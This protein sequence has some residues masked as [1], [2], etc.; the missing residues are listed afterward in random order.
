MLTTIRSLLCLLIITGSFTASAEAIDYSL[1]DLEGKTVSLADYKGKW[2]IVN[3]WATWCPPC[4]E[5]IPDMIKFHDEHKDKDAV[6]LGINAED[7]GLEQLVE[8]TDSMFISYPILRSEP[9][10]ESPLGA[11]PGLPTTYIISPEGEAVARQ[12]GPI[13]SEMIE[14]FISKKKTSSSH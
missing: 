5:E 9:L 11:V 7:I 14:K 3:Y 6:V 1:P 2:V 4:L 13:T 12:V 8:F 10:V